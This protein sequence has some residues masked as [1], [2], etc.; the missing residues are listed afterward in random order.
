M[1]K[2][3]SQKWFFVNSETLTIW[4]YGYGNTPMYTYHYEEKED[5]ERKVNVF[6][7]DNYEFRRDL[8]KEM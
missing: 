6:L 3:L 1:K 8:S 4:T 5:Y 7:S 2:D